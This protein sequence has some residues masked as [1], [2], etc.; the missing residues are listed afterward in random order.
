MKVASLVTEG[1]AELKQTIMN[2]RSVLFISSENAPAARIEAVVSDALSRGEP[3]TG[4]VWSRVEALFD[5]LRALQERSFDLIL[6]DLFLP[7]GQGL[8]T[9]RHLQQHAP[10]TPVIVFCHSQDRDTA[11]TSV[12]KGAYDFFCYEDLDTASLRRS[13][14][15]ALQHAHSEAEKKAAAERRNNARFPCRLA[16]S[17][18]SLEHPILSGQGTS[19][20]LNISSK[21][22]LFTSNEKFHAGQLVQVSLD[23]PARLENQIPLKLVAEGRIVR[24]AGGQTAMTIEKYEFRTRRA[25]R[26]AEAVNKPSLSRPSEAAQNNV[27][28]PGTAAGGKINGASE[29]RPS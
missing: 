28:R 12:R 21:G 29:R 22:I 4:L 18:Q 14:E 3:A 5:G 20:T 25:A 8:A 16:I 19:E 6:S 1:Y 23:W 7:D 2:D 11:V 10:Q 15:G 9:L 17:Y 13:V 27:S 24:N 26:P